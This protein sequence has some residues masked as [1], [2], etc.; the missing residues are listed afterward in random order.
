MVDRRFI[1]DVMLA[2]L[3]SV[4]T[5]A[6]ARQGTVPHRDSPAVQKSVVALAPAADRQVGFFR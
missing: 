5:V 6:L 1:G 4:P 3:I 2:V